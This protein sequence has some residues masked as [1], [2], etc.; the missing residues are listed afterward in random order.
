MYSIER[1]CLAEGQRHDNRARGRDGDGCEAAT[2]RG[3][4]LP[5][6]AV[7]SPPSAGTIVS[8]GA[9]QVEG[10]GLAVSTTISKGYAHVLLGGTAI[11][12]TIKAGAFL[13]VR[14]DRGRRQHHRQQ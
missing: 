10:G 11:S 1:G 5:L 4:F 7:S 3:Q 13:R 14:L 8:G 9:Q 2:R 12:V 6:D